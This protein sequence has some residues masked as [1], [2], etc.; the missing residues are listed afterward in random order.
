MI[1]E[2]L[3]SLN[4]FLFY[5]LKNLCVVLGES[6]MTIHWSQLPQENWIMT[7]LGSP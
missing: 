5:L 6:R 1:Q 7:I 3:K 2:L 4:L